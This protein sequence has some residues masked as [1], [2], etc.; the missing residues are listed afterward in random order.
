VTLGCEPGASLG[1]STCG[2][3]PNQQV[4]RGPC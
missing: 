2:A 4:G 1:G 3:L